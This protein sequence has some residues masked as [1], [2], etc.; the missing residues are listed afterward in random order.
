MPTSYANLTGDLS[1]N[2]QKAKIKLDFYEN[3]SWSFSDFAKEI[4]RIFR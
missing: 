2:A 4:K 3:Y 1:K